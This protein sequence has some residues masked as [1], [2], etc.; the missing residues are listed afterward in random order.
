MVEP[1]DLS[2]K[3]T[4]SNIG[5]GLSDRSSSVDSLKK[6]KSPRK[7]NRRRFKRRMMRSRSRSRSEEKEEDF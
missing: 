2:Y 5:D 4:E 1:D 6:G 7:V 3:E